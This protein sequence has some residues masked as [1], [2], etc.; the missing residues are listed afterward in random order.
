MSTQNKETAQ[1]GNNGDQGG[2]DKQ[3]GTSDDKCIGNRRVRTILLSAL[4]FAFSIFAAGYLFELADDAKELKDAA[5]KDAKHYPGLVHGINFVLAGLVICMIFLI[6]QFVLLFIPSCNPSTNSRARI[7]GIGNVLGGGLYLFGWIYY[8][9]K[10][11]EIFYDFL[12]DEE[13]EDQ[14]ALC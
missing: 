2:E 4:L 3:K 8:I 9:S 11:K 13:K 7:P 6:I 1:D 10:Q 5:G 12:T 14:D